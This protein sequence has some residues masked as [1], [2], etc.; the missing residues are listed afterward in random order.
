MQEELEKKKYVLIFYV[1][2]FYY[3]RFGM[4]IMVHTLYFIEL[5]DI[6]QYIYTDT[7]LP[8]TKYVTNFQI[9]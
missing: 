4:K 3:L 5:C 2:F 1:Q 8:D 9:N 6:F 7:A